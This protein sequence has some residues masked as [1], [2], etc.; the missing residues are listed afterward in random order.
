MYKS[1]VVLQRFDAVLVGFEMRKTKRN[2]YPDNRLDTSHCI[3][4]IDMVFFFL[5]HVRFAD[6]W[7]YVIK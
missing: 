6:I 3:N 5:E 2:K 4:D 7:V 1:V